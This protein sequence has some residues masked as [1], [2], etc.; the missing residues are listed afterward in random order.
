[1]PHTGARA[2]YARRVTLA[3]QRLGRSAERL[4]ASRL[5]AQ[6]YRILER[7]ARVRTPELIGELDLIALDGDVLAFV[8][9]KAGRTGAWFGPE[10]PALAVDRRKQLRLRRL[11]GAW[12]AERR[13]LPRFGA[14]RFDVVGVQFDA[15][16]NV[17]A[18]EHLQAAF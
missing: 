16:G 18:W 6:G 8:E 14:L 5:A 17:V 9:V 3:R 10:L 7:N 4:A 13:S 2:A 1:V 11:A 15:S 12:L